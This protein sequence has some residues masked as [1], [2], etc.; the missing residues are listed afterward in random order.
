MMEPLRRPQVPL[1]EPQSAELAEP[2][3]SPRTWQK[4]TNRNYWAKLDPL[5]FARFPVV[6]PLPYLEES[7]L[8]E[9]AQNGDIDARNTLWRQHLRLAFSVVNRFHLPQSLLADAIQEAAIGLVAAI[10]RFDVHR[11]LAF[12]TYAW[13]WMEQRVR[14]FLIDN[15]YG[16]RIPA[17]LHGEYHRF[18][19]G[20]RRCRSRADLF[21][22]RE[23]WLSSNPKLFD[24]LSRF[25]RLAHPRSMDDAVDLACH[26]PDPVSTIQR[27][28]VQ[29]L[30]RTTVDR[31][32]ARE[33]YIIVRRYGL[34]GEPKATL[35]EIGQEIGLTRERVRQL[36]LETLDDLRRDLE[37]RQAGRNSRNLENRPVLL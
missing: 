13:H 34:D 12:S 28:D 18:K 22:W 23:E 11:Y 37:N 10:E 16:V 29:A 15:R 24:H 30:V 33:A 17:Y 20:L 26:M 25:H 19:R 5:D 1:D 6:K 27:E 32:L 2:K 7:R 21:D 14:R 36:E 9:R 3:E 4:T 8:F 31:L 35:K